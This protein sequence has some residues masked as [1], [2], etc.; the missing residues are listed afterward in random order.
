MITDV[1]ADDWRKKE[2]GAG[3]YV[4]RYFNRII[5]SFRIEKNLLDKDVLVE[6][7]ASK[8]MRIGVA[9]ADSRDLAI[10]LHN[11]PH[12][13]MRIKTQSIITTIV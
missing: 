13:T 3:R 11:Y 5:S 2:T 8:S 1:L 6:D 10:A 12:G 7:F 4:I 9:F